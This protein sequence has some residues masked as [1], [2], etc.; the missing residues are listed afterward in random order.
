MKATTVFF[1]IAHHSSKSFNI[2]GRRQ[3][4][5]VANTC[6]YR[7]VTR[8]VNR[9]DDRMNIG[10]EVTPKLIWRRIGPRKARDSSCVIARSR[11]HS[12]LGV[13]MRQL[14]GK[15]GSGGSQRNADTMPSRVGPFGVCSGKVCNN[16]GAVVVRGTSLKNN[17]RV[18]RNVSVPTRTKVYAVR[19]VIWCSAEEKGN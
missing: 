19:I 1:R 9:Q 8:K 17:G 7:R 5:R 2:D 16:D 15:I 14:D 6:T 3:S 11:C 18:S 10:H 4:D 12:P 13:V